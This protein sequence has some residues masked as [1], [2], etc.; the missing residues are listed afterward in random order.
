MSFSHMVLLAIIAVIVIPPDKLP[1]VA[2]NF[3]RFLGDMRRMTLGLW[4]DLK[5]DSILKPDEFLKQKQNNVIRPPEVTTPTATL[6]AEATSSTAQ[7]AAPGAAVA[8]DEYLKH[9]QTESAENV[10]TTEKKPT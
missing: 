8:E 4:D 7:A 5:Q 6:P 10:K 9:I 2:R 1:E 3:A